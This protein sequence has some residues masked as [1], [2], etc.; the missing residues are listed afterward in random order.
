MLDF[1]R[2][3]PLPWTAF[4]HAVANLNKHCGASDDGVTPSCF[5][6][7]P[8]PVLILFH[9]YFGALVLGCDFPEF[10][11]QSLAFSLHKVSCPISISDFR[12]VVLDS[13]LLKVFLG[14][15]FN[16]CRA[17]IEELPLNMNIF[18]G[19]KGQQGANLI[20]TVQGLCELTLNARH[21]ATAYCR[22]R[23]SQ[24]LGQDLSFLHCLHDR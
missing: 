2:K 18:A 19:K 23:Y 1:K 7:L 4:C 16:F 11:E 20:F 8:I 15:I 3:N 6:N 12:A 9:T 17:K 21:R 5:A 22:Q 24:S 14:S 13:I 10:W